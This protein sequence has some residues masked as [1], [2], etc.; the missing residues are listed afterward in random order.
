[1]TNAFHWQG[2]STILDKMG[3][4]KTERQTLLDATRVNQYS[5]FGRSTNS[6][7]TKA[8]VGK[9]NGARSQLGAS[10]SSSIASSS[11]ALYRWRDGWVPTKTTHRSTDL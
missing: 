8:I 4:I 11:C 9:P 10:L 6:D 7:K 3:R 2:P 5:D 1:V